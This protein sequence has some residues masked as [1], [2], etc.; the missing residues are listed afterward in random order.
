[1][2]RQ[3]SWQSIRLMTGRVRVRIPIGPPPLVGAHTCWKA[4]GT[5]FDNKRECPAL[6]MVGRERIAKAVKQTVIG[7]EAE[8]KRKYGAGM[9]KQICSSI[10]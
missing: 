7:G 6:A 3:L 10:Y 8:I 9:Q 4:M 5:T 1:M 2:D